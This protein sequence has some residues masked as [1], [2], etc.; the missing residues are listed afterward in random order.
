M[1]KQVSN[2]P[3]KLAIRS[4]SKLLRAVVAEACGLSGKTKS[5]NR[6]GIRPARKL[7]LHSATMAFTWKNSLKS[8]A[9]LK[10]RS[11]VTNTGQYVTYQN[12]IVQYNAATKNWL[13]KLPLLLSH[14]SYVPRWEKRP[15]KEHKR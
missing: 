15:S 10:Y 8:P 5:L 11:S 7:P 4:S 14:R 12:G 6:I 9:T 13:K 1:S 2:W 3:T